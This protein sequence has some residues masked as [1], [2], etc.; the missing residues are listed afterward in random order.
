M[1]RKVKAAG[2]GG[3]VATVVVFVLSAVGV[4]LPADVAAAVAAIISVV[5]GYLVPEA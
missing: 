3:A 1:K 5:A 2:I 4:E